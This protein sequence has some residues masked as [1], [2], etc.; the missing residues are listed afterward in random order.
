MAQRSPN[1]PQI[2]FQEAI[3]KGRKVYEKEHTHSAAKLTVAN[4]LGYSG[5]NGRSLSMIGALRQY[6]I[7]EGGADALKVSDD[8]M[9]YYV[10]DDG[11]QKQE[12]IRS[13]VLRPALF[14]ELHQQF[15]GEH[16]P[17]EGNLKH[18]L[19]KRGFL[20]DAADEVIRV[21]RANSELVGGKTVEY[22]EPQETAPVAT[23]PITPAVSSKTHAW[24]WTLS[25]PRSVNA[26][27]RIAGDVTKADIARLKRQ[28][29]FLAESFDDEAAE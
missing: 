16:L 10:M 9:V 7:L 8:A 23:A 2:T 11:P 17:S 12:A 28:I 4:D 20:P 27:L 15:G 19:I 14:S 22:T 18:I 5:I 1:C 13:M 24:T 25:V 21:Y 3:E 29:D 26:E 6:G